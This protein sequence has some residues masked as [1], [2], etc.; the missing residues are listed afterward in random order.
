MLV[1]LPSDDSD[2][3]QARAEIEVRCEFCNEL[4]SVAPEEV[5]ARRAQHDSAP[6]LANVSANETVGK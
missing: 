5:A 1:S 6:L 4:Y 3:L 2:D